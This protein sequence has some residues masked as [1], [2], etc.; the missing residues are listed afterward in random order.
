M[1]GQVS[2]KFAGQ[3]GRLEIPRAD[4][5]SLPMRKLRHKAF[6]DQARARAGS[7]EAESLLLPGVGYSEK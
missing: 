4:V 6:T 5:V 7:L 3:V 1:W 2:L